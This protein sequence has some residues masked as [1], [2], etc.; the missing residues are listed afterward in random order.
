MNANSETGDL[1]VRR[2][3]AGEEAVLQELFFQTIRTVNLR[4]YSPEQVRA[5]APDEMDKERWRTRIAGMNP[6]VCVSE[7]QITGYAGLLPTGHVDHFFVHR[8]WQRRGV[9]RALMQSLLEEA[10]ALSLSELTSDVSITARPFFEVH[11]FLV[12]QQQTVSLGEVNL[13]NFRMKRNLNNA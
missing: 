8:D 10:A 6:F 11:G 5:W 2:Y 9:G 1:H 12:E 4:D 13:T 3:R 7:D